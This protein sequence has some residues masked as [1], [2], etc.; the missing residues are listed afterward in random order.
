MAILSAVGCAVVR[1]MSQVVTYKV[2]KNLVSNLTFQFLQKMV[3]D[4]VSLSVVS[5]LIIVLDIRDKIFLITL[6]EI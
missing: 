6:L 4:G 3:I 5:T 1:E 2:A